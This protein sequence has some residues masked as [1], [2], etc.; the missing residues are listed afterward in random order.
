M[1]DDYSEYRQVLAPGM[2]IE[3]GIPLSGGGVFRDWG[4][5]S[6]SGGDL[7]QLQ[8]SRDV[9]P[10]NVRVDIGFILDVSV[11]LGKDSYTCSGIV[12][13][14]LG[15]RVLQI[16]LFGRFTLR[17][18]RQFFRTDM[19]LRVRYD[20]VDESSRKEVERDWEVRKER[21]QMK[22]Q[23]YDDFVIAAQMARFKPATDIVWRDLLRAQLNLGGGGICLRMPT[24]ARP[25]QLV[26]MELY[27]PLEPPRLVHAVGQV[28]HVKPPLTQR[29]GSS[30]YDVGM[31]FLFLDERDRDLI[32]KQISSVQ[33]AHL[34]RVADKR[35]M[36]E[37]SDAPPVAL[38]RRQYLVRALWVLVALILAYALG[39]YFISYSQAPPENEIQKTYEESI[40][41]YRHLDKQP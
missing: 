13:D 32:F 18:R 3:I 6:E 11:Y 27:L 16:R 34:R 19:A 12:T 8:I 26:N 30:R 17:E 37:P 23:G 36:D 41:K 31:E 9:L 4:V 33:I 29:D 2:R 10:A 5:I 24:T 28:I 7:L 39:R 35:D 1:E 15:E 40:R 21:E 25:D 20:I 14:R 38:S 22:F